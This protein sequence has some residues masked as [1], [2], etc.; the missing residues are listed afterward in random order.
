MAAPTPIVANPLAAQHPDP[1]RPSRTTRVPN[2][3][4]PI[5]GHL[6]PR[7]PHPVEP[8]LECTNTNLPNEPK[9]SF[10]FNNIHFHDEPNEPMQPKPPQQSPKSLCY[11]KFPGGAPMRTIS[12]ISPPAHKPLRLEPGAQYPHALVRSA[13]VS[14][15]IGKRYEL[16]AWV[17]TENVTVRDTDRSPIATGAALSMASMPFDVHSETLAGS[18]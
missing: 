8:P 2:E 4:S 9:A 12:N 11:P 5:S 15:T 1:G 10:I 3:P 16:S 6:P 7:H 13:P 17:R 14:L 18:H